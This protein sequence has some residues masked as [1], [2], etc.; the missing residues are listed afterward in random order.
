M[1]PV[2]F[3]RLYL[4]KGKQGRD[5]STEVLK[6]I[7]VLKDTCT[8]RYLCS[9]WGIA[10]TEDVAKSNFKG[11]ASYWLLTTHNLCKKYF[12]TA[13]LGRASSALPVA[14]LYPKQIIISK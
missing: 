7:S 3:V 13:I 2:M 11:L 10:S 12:C 8:K 5:S 6:N 1:S 4:R 14:Q 9:D